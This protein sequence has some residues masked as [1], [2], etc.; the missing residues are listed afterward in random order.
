MNN[1]TAPR[2]VPITNY[3]IPS[4]W[5]LAFIFNAVR[6]SQGSGNA[7]LLLPLALQPVELCPSIFSCPKLWHLNYRRRE[8]TQKKAHDIQNKVKVWN[9]EL[10]HC[11]HIPVLSTSLPAVIRDFK[12]Q[13][14]I[15]F[16]QLN[17]LETLSPLFHNWDK[18]CLYK[19]CK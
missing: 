13:S 1:C 14:H 17:N 8:I 5:F 19:M 7:K 2:L 16:T 3:E 10:I 6:L 11:S 15:K 9:Q 4:S 18:K 12:Y